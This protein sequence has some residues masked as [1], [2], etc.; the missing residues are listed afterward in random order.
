[1][2]RDCLLILT[3]CSTAAAGCASA[4]TSAELA[5][6]EAQAAAGEARFQAMY[7]EA[8]RL[9]DSAVAGATTGAGRLMELGDRAIR[10]SGKIDTQCRKIRERDDKAAEAKRLGEAA[11]KAF[12]AEK[13]ATKLIAPVLSTDKATT[14]AVQKSAD[15]ARNNVDG[16]ESVGTK[17]IFGAA[18]KAIDKT[19]PSGFV[20]AV[21]K[22]ASQ[23]IEKQMTQT[24]LGVDK[25]AK[26]N[27]SGSG[28]IADNSTIAPPAF[29]VL[30]PG[31]SRIED[32][33]PEDPSN[34]YSNANLATR[35]PVASARVSNSQSA[36][37]ESRVV[38]VVNDPW[39]P[40]QVAPTEGAA[41]WAAEQDRRTA[42][43]AAQAKAEQLE[44][45]RVAALEEER[46]ERATKN[47]ANRLRR[48]EIA[49]KWERDDA[50][51]RRQEARED[52]RDAREAR[53]RIATARAAADEYRQRLDTINRS[54]AST[55]SSSIG[56]TGTARTLDRSTCRSGPGTCTS[57]GPTAKEL[58]VLR[59]R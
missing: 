55:S 12:E 49:R 51:F 43:A 26:F 29:A 13:A 34:P 57:D 52:A 35:S 39:S 1:M 10:E 46:R 16:K 25:F 11:R 37:P 7:A 42:R 47:E 45:Q 9:L 41:I 48:E 28:Q 27:P 8:G 15:V 23:E 18:D 50:E 20:G 31:R 33:R 56:D 59:N 22:S 40:P 32:S 4:Q 6:C 21:Q 38:G 19:A 24:L 14:A 5:G 3:L 36:N 54:I 44:R 30:G 17:L 53:E 58:S 2:R